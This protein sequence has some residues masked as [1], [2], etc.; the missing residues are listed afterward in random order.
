MLGLHA[1]WDAKMNGVNPGTIQYGACMQIRKKKELPLVDAA[2]QLGLVSWVNRLEIGFQPQIIN[3][4]GS[5][6]PCEGVNV[7]THTC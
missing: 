4:V 7:H 6:T 1:V 2:H 5:M 3:L